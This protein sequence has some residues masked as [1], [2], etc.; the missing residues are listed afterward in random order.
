MIT[1]LITYVIDPAKVDVMAVSARA[2]SHLVTR[3][4]GTHHGVFLP[5][6]G[7]NN[8][9]WA[10]FS[11]HALAKFSA[12]RSGMVQLGACPRACAHGRNTG[13]IHDFTRPVRDGASPKVLG[14]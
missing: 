7:A 10:L 2:W 3:I 13:C 1:A 4:G 6:E 8:K 9:A 5:S 11:F 12:Y 14:L